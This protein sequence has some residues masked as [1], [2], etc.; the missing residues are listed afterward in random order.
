MTG[1]SAAPFL[2]HVSCLPLL[3]PACG[4]HA[5]TES[6]CPIRRLGSDRHLVALTRLSLSLPVP[7]PLVKRQAQGPD[8]PAA[9]LLHHGIRASYSSS[10]SSPPPCRRRQHLRRT[11]RQRYGSGPETPTV[12]P[13]R[14]AV[15]AQLWLPFNSYQKE[16][17]Y[18]S[19]Y[20][21]GREEQRIVE[22][23]ESE[24]ACLAVRDR[25]ENGIH[26]NWWSSEA[27]L[28]LGD[29]FGDF[30]VT[31]HG[32]LPD[33]CNL[34]REFARKS[35]TKMTESLQRK[36]PHCTIPILGGLFRTLLR[37]ASARHIETV[38][39]SERGSAR[40]GRPKNARQ[41][42]SASYAAGPRIR[43]PSRST[44]VLTRVRD[45]G[46]S[47]HVKTPLAGIAAE[48]ARAE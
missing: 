45:D 17:C 29:C 48:R 12:F 28:K 25:P 7:V 5:R 24:A 15:R 21:C 35:P 36:L 41:P 32:P 22:K 26:R 11:A 42:A 16:A 19:K 47:L 30:G 2:H 33:Q 14:Q 37:D 31:G 8:K 13:R 3:K 4:P 44:R 20:Y 9:A 6:T 34:C 1:K 43:A 23:Y 39:A 27:A 40:P 10:S 46:A 38:Q 18:G